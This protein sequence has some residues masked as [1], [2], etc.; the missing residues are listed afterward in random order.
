MSC[1]CSRCD[2]AEDAYQ[3]WAAE[4]RE[5]REELHDQVHAKGPSRNACHAEKA[6]ADLAEAKLAIE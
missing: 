1:P 5:D 2:A 4:Q 6:C 3:Q